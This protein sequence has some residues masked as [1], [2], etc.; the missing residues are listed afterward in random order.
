LFAGIFQRNVIGKP[1]LDRY[2]LGMGSPLYEELGGNRMKLDLFHD[3]TLDAMGAYLTRL[4]QRQQIVASNLANIDTPGYRTK[5]VSF[6]ATMEEL[7]LE[8]S[9][10][11]RTTRSDHDQAWIPISPQAQAFEVQGMVSRFDLNNVDIDK[12]ML[13][14]SETAFGY[15]LI[16]QL[17]RGKF[18]TLASS[19]NEGRTA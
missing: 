16:T 18:R 8:N 13:K 19:I 5:D 2:L 1:P 14:L 6:H 12:E 17:V 3:P 15:S 4:S 10:G 7:L 9:L 11:L